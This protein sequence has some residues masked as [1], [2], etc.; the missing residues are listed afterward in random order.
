M[1]AHTPDLKGIE[2]TSEG[3]LIRID[4]GISAYYGGPRSYLE[5][6]DGKAIAWHEDNQGKWISEA[7]PSPQ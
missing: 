1:V 4:T 2:A 5:I 3:R 6:V 7:L